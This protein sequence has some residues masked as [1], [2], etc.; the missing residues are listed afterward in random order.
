M[1]SGGGLLDRLLPRAMVANNRG[2]SYRWR[3]RGADRA[4][5]DAGPRAAPPARTPRCRRRAPE[6]GVAGRR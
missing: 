3:E 2:T 4:P 5:G 6:T 1:G